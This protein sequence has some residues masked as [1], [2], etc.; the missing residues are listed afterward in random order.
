MN[1]KFN[2]FRVLFLLALGALFSGC[3]SGGVAT[4]PIEIVITYKGEKVEGALVTLAP[5]V[6]DGSQR[7]ATGMTDANG[8]VGITTPAGGN[9]AMEGDFK[10]IVMKTP[11]IGGKQDETPVFATFEEA[12]VHSSS[13]NTKMGDDKPKHQLPVKY[14]SEET[15]DLT[16]S[17]K[18]GDKNSWTFD[19]TD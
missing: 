11:Q 14:A 7:T 6:K 13:G 10:V 16:V 18:K 5:T 2:I 9:G 17:V 8:K 3:N 19:L 12:V 1:T 4:V 15:T